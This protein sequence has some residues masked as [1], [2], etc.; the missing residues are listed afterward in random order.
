MGINCIYREGQRC[1]Y[2]G[3]R[4]FRMEDDEM[5]CRNQVEDIEYNEPD[6]D[7]QISYDENDA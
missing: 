2:R 1:M 3:T 4:C 5:Y 7:V 6:F